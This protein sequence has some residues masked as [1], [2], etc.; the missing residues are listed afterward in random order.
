MAKGVFDELAR[1]EPRNHFTIGIVDDVTHTS[2]RWDRDFSTEGRGRAR[3]LLRAR[4]RRHGG[5]R[6]EHAS[7]SSAS[8]TPLHA[9]GYFVYD[10]K[11][12]GAVTVS[13]LRFGPR[14]IRST[15]QIERAEFVACH[16]FDLLERLDVLERAAPGAR[17]L[18]NSPHSAERRLGAPAA[19][20]AGAGRSRSGS[21]CGWSTPTAS[22]ARSAWAAASTP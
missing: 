13:H 1:R 3:A 4:Q 21:S 14:P 15:Y 10:S 5:R 7:R 6:Q 12:S 16:Q 2:L 11:K 19:R 9:Q 8:E 20:G 17:L 22:R 18:L